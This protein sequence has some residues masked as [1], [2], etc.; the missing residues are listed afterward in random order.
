[1]TVAH[2]STIAEARSAILA[3][4][5]DALLFQGTATKSDWGG[6]PE[7]VDLTVDTRGM[8]RLLDHN[9]GDFTAVVEAG[10]RMEVLQAAL[11]AEGQW[12]AADVFGGTVGGVVATSDFGP[13][14]LRYG[15]V[16]NVILGMTVLLGDG[17][18]AR[19]GGRVIKNVAGYDLSKVF[20]GSFGTLGMIGEVVLRLH[21]VPQRS[22]TVVIE[23]TVAM[24]LRITLELLRA[25]IEPSA[26]DWADGALHIRLEGDS[27]LRG[28]KD[29]VTAVVRRNGLGYEVMDGVEESSRWRQ[30]IA[31]STGADGDTVAVV[32][33]LPS[34]M[35]FVHDS[36]HRT[37]EATGVDVAVH[38]LT[39]VGLHIA[40]V[41]GG[42]AS[43]HAAVVTGWRRQLAT[44]G[45]LV[46]L[47][48]Q[49]PGLKALVDS[50]G[51]PPAGLEA[52]RRL[53]QSLD[54]GRRCA[55]GRFVGGL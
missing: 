35:V 14:R 31:A 49:T 22:C 13:R 55:P 8:D 46:S 54:P 19:T 45:A 12:F 28:Q 24:G 6:Q 16:R 5:S 43:E 42:D 9:P 2:P 33:S 25:P 29:V 18:I 23:A 15:P 38:S 40:R 37:A 7:R 26:V 36:L 21:P 20:C 27:R 1:M 47:R 17:T 30:M 52:M 3:G 44:E 32:A 39:A 53:K 48:R 51:P 10:M 11:A 50:W 4:G 41:R 34:Q